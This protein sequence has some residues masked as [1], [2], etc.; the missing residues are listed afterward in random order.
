MMCNLVHY[1]IVK[2]TIVQRKPVLFCTPWKTPGRA[3]N[4]PRPSEDEL[5]AKECQSKAKD[6]RKSAATVYL[7]MRLYYLYTLIK[8]EYII[9]SKEYVINL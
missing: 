4:F 9:H 8:T 7:F 1:G 2:Y 6:V 5:E 3:V